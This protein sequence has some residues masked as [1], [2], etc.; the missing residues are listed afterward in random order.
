MT[1]T[2]GQLRKPSKAITQT[3][4][5]NVRFLRRAKKISQEE[6][7]EISGLHRTYVG[8][9]ER[10]ERNATLS[11]LEV[12]ASA[13]KVSVPELLTPVCGRHEKTR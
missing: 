10:G 3:L 8:S 2:A 13:L 11:T 9:L 4:A 7:A 12:L 1:M 6:L 5:S